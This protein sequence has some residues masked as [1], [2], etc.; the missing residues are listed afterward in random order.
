MCAELCRFSNDQAKISVF[1]ALNNRTSTPR[2]AIY[3]DMLCLT[4]FCNLQQCLDNANAR[5]L[6]DIQKAGRDLKFSA[7]TKFNMTNLYRRFRRSF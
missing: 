7:M 1:H 2:R 5:R 6:P 4:T 3:N